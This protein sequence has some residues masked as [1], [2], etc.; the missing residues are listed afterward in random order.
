MARRTAVPARRPAVLAAWAVA[1]VVAAVVLAGIGAW[2]VTNRADTIDYAMRSYRIQ[3]GGV[4]VTFDVAKKPSSTATCLVRVQDRS[5]AT[6]GARS[7]VVVGP[8]TVGRRVTTLTV[9]VPV[10]GTPITGDVE[11]CT[12]TSTAG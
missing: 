7:D 8:N 6:I 10:H 9:F 3:P 11:K 4:S 5:T 2:L 1:A 12:I